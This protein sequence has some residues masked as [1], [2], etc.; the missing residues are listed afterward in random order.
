MNFLLF[1]SPAVRL[2]ENNNNNIMS[3]EFQRVNFFKYTHILNY[4][5]VCTSCV[6]YCCYYRRKICIQKI[7]IMCRCSTDKPE[8]ITDTSIKS[9]SII[10]IYSLIAHSI[11]PQWFSAHSFHLLIPRHVHAYIRVV[12]YNIENSIIMF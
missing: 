5:A 1:Y 10:N 9:Y 12:V 4:P 11:L 6:R 2:P 7:G 3:V 8:H